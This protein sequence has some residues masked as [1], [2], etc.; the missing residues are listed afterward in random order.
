MVSIEIPGAF[1]LN[2][3]HVLLDFNGTIAVD[4]QLI[5][6]VG[7]KINDLAQDLDFHVITADTFGSVKKELGGIQ[8]ALKVIPEQD[9]ARAKQAYLETLG[10]DKTIAAGN[11]ANDEFMLKESALGVSVLGQE[12]LMSK[13]LMASDI[14]VGDILDLF[15]YLERPGRLVACLR[16]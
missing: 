15:G 8:C 3:Q 2:I 7:E 14:V 10:K 5:K 9:Q 4:G 13:S 6:G 1:T 16:R 12:G 11:G